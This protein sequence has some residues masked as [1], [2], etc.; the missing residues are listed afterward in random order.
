MA[1]NPMQRKSRTSFLLG[2]L[3]TLVIMGAIVAFLFM[4]L[5]KMKNEENERIAASKTVYVLSTDVKSGE[6]LTVENFTT[7]IVDGSAVP[8]NAITTSSLNENTIAKIDLSAGTILTDSM[9]EESENKTTKDSR[10]QEYNMISLA[11][12]I[13]SNDYIDIRLR[14]PSG[15]DYIVVSK[16]R[17]ESSP[18]GESANTVWMKLSE[19]EI[20]TMSNAIVESYIT[21]GSL[22]YA[23]KYVE[24]GMQE[25]ATPTY[26][27]SA[28][29][30]YLISSDS[31]IT[32]E[33]KNALI[34]RYNNNTNIR[35]NIN[36]EKPSDA[37][38]ASSLVSSGTQTE[39]QTTQEQR[40]Q[41][42]QSLTSG[43]SDYGGD[44]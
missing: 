31:N 43:G 16:K 17:L 35:E 6:N 37:D 14:M 22:L 38:E 9:V 15:L 2:M 1:S 13:A 3:I 41:Y 36:G 21:E 10:L 34:T 30:Q 8:S 26:V 20:L 33:A 5:T 25:E 28:N 4:Q 40:Q 24:P 29:V 32:N 23:A 27:P 7:A 11:S 18:V 44:I 42:L 19:D 12:H 39:I